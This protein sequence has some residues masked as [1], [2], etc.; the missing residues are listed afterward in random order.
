MSDSG[1]VIL[2][3][4]H[5]LRED[6]W[7]L[8]TTRE[9]ERWMDGQIRGGIKWEKMLSREE[10]HRTPFIPCFSHRTCCAVCA[11]AAKWSREMPGSKVIEVFKMV[12]ARALNQ[13]WAI[14][15][16]RA[17]CCYTSHMPM[18]PVVSPLLNTASEASAAVGR[19]L[20]M[21]PFP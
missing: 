19:R 13:A 12:L 17:L 15:E 1:W 2:A 20:A 9:L 8:I 6:Y 10:K 4:L 21:F 14:P 7:V 3:W 11:A 18:T 16:C 5:S